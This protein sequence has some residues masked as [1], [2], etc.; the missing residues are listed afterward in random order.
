[1]AYHLHSGSI[2]H[3]VRNITHLNERLL[4]YWPLVAHPKPQGALVVTRLTSWR[5]NVIH[6]VDSLPWAPLPHL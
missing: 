5:L 1:M 3:S 6:T 4:I 2:K